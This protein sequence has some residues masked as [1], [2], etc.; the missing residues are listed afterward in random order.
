MSKEKLIVLGS[1]I[2]IEPPQK[3]DEKTAGGI[4][5]PESAKKKPNKGVVVSAGPE[6]ELKEGDVVIYNKHALR[7]EKY[8]DITYLFGNESAVT[9]KLVSE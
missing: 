2:L 3:E 8:D 4:I 7:E 5:I 1:N 9:F 6:A